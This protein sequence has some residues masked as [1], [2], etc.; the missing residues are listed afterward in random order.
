MAEAALTV[1]LQEGLADV[2]IAGGTESMSLVPMG[3]NK[4]SPNPALVDSP[5]VSATTYP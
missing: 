5:Q 1:T 4:I 2:V 3:G